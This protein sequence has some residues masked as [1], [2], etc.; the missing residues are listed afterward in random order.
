MLNFNWR[1]FA[2]QPK[3]IWK[4]SLI[5]KADQW[6]RWQTKKKIW[7]SEWSQVFIKFVILFKERS[8]FL[9]LIYQT[10]WYE[11]KRQS[12]D[13]A[14]LVILQMQNTIDSANI[15]SN[16]NKSPFRTFRWKQILL[17]TLKRSCF[18]T[19][20]TLICAL[21]L[22]KQTIWTWSIMCSPSKCSVGVSSGTQESFFHSIKW[23]KKK[24][25]IGNR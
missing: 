21:F 12:S 17:P 15:L 13:W 22:L 10:M 24:S 1:Q 18:C 8:T 6:L 23:K 19:G 7:Y 9:A 16:K 2:K 14:L 4:F 11:L 5:L 3:T 20:Q 25:C